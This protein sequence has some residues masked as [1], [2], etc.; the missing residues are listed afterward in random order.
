MIESVAVLCWLKA[1]GSNPIQLSAI[2]C[3]VFRTVQLMDKVKV[4]NVE[5]KFGKDE[6]YGML[7]EY[8]GLFLVFI[9]ILNLLPL[10]DG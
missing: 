1:L 3:W 10:Y 2:I 8:S 6:S 7:V 4:R 9:F 5:T